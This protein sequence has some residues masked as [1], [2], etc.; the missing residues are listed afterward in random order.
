MLLWL[1]TLNDI[2]VNGLVTR[3]VAKVLI[4]R[5]VRFSGSHFDRDTAANTK[6]C[7]R[8]IVIRAFI[9]EDFMTGVPAIPDKHI[10]FAVSIDLTKSFN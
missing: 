10:P 9:T 3:D 2:Q 6:S 5:S 8:S 4:E 7:Q 1:H